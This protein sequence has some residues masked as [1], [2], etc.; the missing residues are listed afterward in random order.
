MVPMSDVCA[1]A[2]P[3]ADGEAFE[4]GGKIEAG[5]VLT[6]VVGPVA[7]ATTVTLSLS[8][9]G[10]HLTSKVAAFAVEYTPAAGGA[11]EYKAEGK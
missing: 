6:A 2:P 1:C 5:S 11:A 10:L 7:S 4:S 8:N 9:A 3:P